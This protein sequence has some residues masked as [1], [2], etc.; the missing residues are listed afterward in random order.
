MFGINT[1]HDILILS[2]ISLAE[3]RY[4]NFSKYQLVIFMQNIT[5]KHAIT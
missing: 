3:I 1:T 5:T 4:N 2:Q